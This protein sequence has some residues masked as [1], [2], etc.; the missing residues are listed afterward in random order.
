MNTSAQV[1]QI[2]ARVLARFAGFLYLV[3]IVFGISSEVLVRARLVVQ[4]DGAATINNIMAS[5]TLFRLGFVADSVM[6][7]SD[8]VIAILFYAL[9]RSVS[10]VLALT[11]AAFRLLQAAIL[12]ANL[13]NYHAV[14][15]L[16]QGK[17]IAP[18]QEPLQDQVMLFLA[19]HSHG[20]DLGLIFFAFSN[21]ILGYLLIRSRLFP[22]FLG[23][24]LQAAGVVYLAGSYTRFLAPDYVSLVQP[25]YIVPLLAELTFCL[26]L[27]IK[28]IKPDAVTA[29]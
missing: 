4:G 25:A 10:P 16:L 7:I 27:L 5:D 26:W 14:L 6:L 1:D 12:A 2:Q 3:I 13:L 24:A 22:S 29:A 17:G 21:F 8:V 11:A 28:G 19:M 20:Y 18:G 23:Y 15:L 9:L